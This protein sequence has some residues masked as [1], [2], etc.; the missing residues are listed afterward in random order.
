[1]TT[2]NSKTENRALDSWL[3]IQI[4]KPAGLPNLAVFGP[5]VKRDT[6]KSCKIR[7]EESV[8]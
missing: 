8:T 5:K 6:T 2:K 7:R 3:L 4:A 1:M